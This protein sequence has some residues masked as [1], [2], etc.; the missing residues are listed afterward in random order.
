MGGA[1]TLMLIMGFVGMRECK[2]GREER[3]EVVVA[4]YSGEMEQLLR[5]AVREGKQRRA[6][7]LLLGEIDGSEER[8]K[9][10]AFDLIGMVARREEDLTSTRESIN[11]I[12]T[13]LE[14][15]L[16]EMKSSRSIVTSQLFT[17]GTGSDREGL[18]VEALQQ[19]R[20]LGQ[21][22]E[23]TLAKSAEIENMFISA[24]QTGGGRI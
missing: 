16:E 1:I 21:H 13:A 22:A 20:S 9:R 12:K 4:F 10:R 6:V 23:G 17:M 5:Q 3:V 19:I 14:Q 18:W 15:G 8:L 2:V 11:T 7:S 24:Q